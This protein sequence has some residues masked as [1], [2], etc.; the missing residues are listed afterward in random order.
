MVENFFYNVHDCHTQKRV[1]FKSFN[2]NNIYGCCICVVP[3]SVFFACLFF[4]RTVFYLNFAMFYSPTLE[5]NANIVRLILT[6]I[7][8]YL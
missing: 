7:E 2:I 3:L 5:N 6:N 4:D 8:R 1:L